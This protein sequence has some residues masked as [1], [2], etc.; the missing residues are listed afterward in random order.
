MCN[1]STNSEWNLP[2]C[3]QVISPIRCQTIFLSDGCSPLY[4]WS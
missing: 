2:Y 3:I 4:T 1:K